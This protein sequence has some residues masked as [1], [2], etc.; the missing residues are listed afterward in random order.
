MKSRQSSLGFEESRSC[1]IEDCQTEPNHKTK[2]QNTDHLGKLIMLIIDSTTI[3]NGSFS[4]FQV[5]FSL[6][7]HFFTLSFDT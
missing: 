4:G 2:R 3:L 6:L 7:N 5:D 1:G